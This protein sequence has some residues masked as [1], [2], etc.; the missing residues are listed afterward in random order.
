VT[1]W[2]IAKAIPWAL[3]LMAMV[4]LYQRG[5]H[6]GKADAHRDTLDRYQKTRERM[7]DVKVGNDP[8]VLRE[9]LSERGKQ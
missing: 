2:L 5:R 6:D 4:G 3:G 8:A 9:W 7:D 1:A